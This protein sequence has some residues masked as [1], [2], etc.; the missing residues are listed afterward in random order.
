MR[1]GDAAALR[2]RG[3]NGKIHDHALADKLLRQIF[4]DQRNIFLHGQLV[5]EG[6]VIAVGKLGLLVFL[7]L[8]HGVP[9]GFPVRVL[10]GSVGRQKDVG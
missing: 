3:V 8:L 4:P 5:L 2:V 6:N 10:R 7:R 9:E 1:V